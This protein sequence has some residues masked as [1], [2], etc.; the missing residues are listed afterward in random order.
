M[1][2]AV[3]IADLHPPLRVINTRGASE[4]WLAKRVLAHVFPR[5]SNDGLY[6]GRKASYTTG[7]RIELAA[8]LRAAAVAANGTEVIKFV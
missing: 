6:G 1:A 2:W 7:E 3:L 8:R 4:A 5:Y